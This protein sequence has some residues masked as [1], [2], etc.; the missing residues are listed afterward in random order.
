LAPDT[1]TTIFSATS[2]DG[3]DHLLGGAIGATVTCATV[4]QATTRQWAAQAMRQEVAM[5]SP[6]KKPAPLVGLDGRDDPG[7]G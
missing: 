4:L 6:D 2:R 7:V 5:T 1:G 3:L